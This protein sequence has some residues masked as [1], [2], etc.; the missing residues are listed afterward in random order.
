M[1]PVRPDALD[2]VQF[3]SVRGQILQLDA[4]IETAQEVLDN[5]ATVRRQPVPDDQKR[6]AEVAHQ[7]LEEIHN[8]RRL[9]GSGIQPKVKVPERQPRN[10][11]QAFPIE[12]V[13]QD[14][15]LASGRPSATAMG[16]LAQSAFVDE[17]DCAPLLAGFF[18]MP[19]QV[20]FFQVRI[21]SSFRSRALPVGR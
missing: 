12:I 4:A 15:S 7:R 5:P 20:F 18:L 17:N 21:C 14:R 10:R 13:F 19:G 1:L 2:R 11:R 3:G 16:P 6:P 8:L 9:H